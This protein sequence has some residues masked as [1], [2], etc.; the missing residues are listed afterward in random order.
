MARKGKDM[1]KETYFILKYGSMKLAFK[2]WFTAGWCLFDNP[3]RFK[4]PNEEYQLLDEFFKP[5]PSAEK[6]KYL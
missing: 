6:E 1:N 5:M 2:V 3:D 4:M